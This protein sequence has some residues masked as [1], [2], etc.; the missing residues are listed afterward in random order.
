MAF[1]GRYVPLGKYLCFPVCGFGFDNGHHEG[2]ESAQTAQ[3]DHVQDAVTPGFGFLFGE[4]GRVFRVEIVPAED[5]PDLAHLLLS[6]M[7]QMYHH[8][9]G[10]HIGE[11][12][13]HAHIHHRIAVTEV[14]KVNPEIFFSVGDDIA[15]LQVPVQAGH[16]IGNRIDECQAFFTD[17]L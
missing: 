6:Q 4:D 17:C 5:L 11:K 2:L 7:E 10:S 13:P 15:R 1:A 12:I 16:G 14:R 3:I 9:F 8:R